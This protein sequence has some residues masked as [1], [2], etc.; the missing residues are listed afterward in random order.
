LALI[1]LGGLWL[2]IWRRRWRWWGLLPVLAGII[3]AM[4][5]SRPDLLIA[6]SPRTIALR[7]PDGLLHFP[8]TPKD[9]YA[10]ARWLLRDGD[11]RD[12]RDAVG[13]PV[14]SCDDLGCVTRQAGLLIAMPWRPEALGD[15]CTRA[16]IVISAAPITFCEQPRL[17][18][19]PRDIAAA[20]G[21]AI[22]LSPLHVTSVNQWRGAR[23]WV[24]DN[25]QPV[26]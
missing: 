11:R 23:P 3:L 18:L 5:A 7:G 6:S 13:A 4:T 9:G 12:W 16:D 1:A 15:D 17:A 24:R 8:R 25:A 22:A 10:A 2:V 26:Q 20:G 14:T 21:Y 19:G